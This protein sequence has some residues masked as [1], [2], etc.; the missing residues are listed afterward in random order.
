MI[1]NEVGEPKNIERTIKVYYE[2]VYPC[3]FDNLDE[4]NQFCKGH[5]FPK[6]IR[7]ELASV[8]GPKWTL[9]RPLQTRFKPRTY[10][11]TPPAMELTK[12]QVKCGEVTKKLE[13]SQTAGGQVKWCGHS[14]DVSQQ[15]DL[16]LSYQTA[17][18]FHPRQSLRKTKRSVHTKLVREC[19]QHHDP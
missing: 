11:F 13:P 16:A 17:Q 2:Q 4:I 7:E 1:R 3:I 14:L 18:Q 10:H 6:L 19:S 12:R 15:V 8:K 5:R 9:W